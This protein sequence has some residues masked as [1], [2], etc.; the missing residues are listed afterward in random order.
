M[1][2]TSRPM[3]EADAKAVVFA[4]AKRGGADVAQAIDGV[5]EIGVVRQ[6]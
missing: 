6:S 3:T 4:Q 1:R 5:D 2:W